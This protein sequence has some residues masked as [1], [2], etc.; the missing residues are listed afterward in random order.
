MQSL[1]IKIIIIII[2]FNK[3]FD[4]HFVLAGNY[5]HLQIDSFHSLS[6]RMCIRDTEQNHI[7]ML[8]E[9][10]MK[11][12]LSCPQITFLT[13]VLREKIKISRKLPWV[14]ISLILI[15]SGV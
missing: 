1:T 4:K 2:S 13:K 9:D 14:I 10:L 15:T 6:F 11:G 8:L 3:L 7:K 5:I 12:N